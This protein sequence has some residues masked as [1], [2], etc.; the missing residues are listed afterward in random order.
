M[1]SDKEVETKIK[2]KLGIFDGRE[3]IPSEL[4]G[5]SDI[6]ITNL[7]AKGEKIGTD[8]SELVKLRKLKVL[9]LKG[10]DLD[11]TFYEVMHS[12][13]ELA[14]LSFYECHLKEPL[15]IRI[16]SLRDLIMMRCKI[17][18]LKN[19]Q[20]PANVMVNSG[21]IIDASKFVHSSHLKKLGI[22]NSDINHAAYFEQMK[23]LKSLNVDGS[24]L[25]EPDVI[26][27]LRE[28]KIAVSYGFEYHPIR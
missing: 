4:D 9:G 25:D 20:F 12:F 26:Q 22:N 24:N 6:M 16:N 19:I 10:F 13:P 5:V 18:N 3:P 2:Y 8:I 23:A 27:R 21:G 14:S 28:K 7:N 1:F 11:E 17:E 15:E